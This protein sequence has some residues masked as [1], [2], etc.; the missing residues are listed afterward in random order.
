MCPAVDWECLSPLPDVQ[1]RYRKEHSF[2]KLRDRYRSLPKEPLLIRAELFEPVIPAEPRGALHLDSLL[3]T[4]VLDSH[5]KA[6]VYSNGF[7]SVA[8]L[9]LEL[10]WISEEGRPLWVCSELRA[11]GDVLRAPFYWHKRYPQDRAHLGTK[12]RAEAR[13]GRWKEYRMPLSGTVVPELRGVCIGN[14]EEV[15]RLLSSLTHIGKKIG[16]GF[17]RVA[18]SVDRLDIDSEIIRG[19]ALRCRSVPVKYIMDTE[20]EL[21]LKENVSYSRRS[22]CA[23]SWYAPWHD[24]SVVR[25]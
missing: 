9:P 19:V 12:V 17:G 10:E 11:Q 23:P 21:N 25:S 22:W 24:L 16:Y 20:G 18:W 2:T 15:A 6:P 8:P 3:G 13:S 5:P 1:A 14:A 4:R 7:P